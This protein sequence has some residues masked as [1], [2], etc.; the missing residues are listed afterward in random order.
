MNKID[1]LAY[2]KKELYSKHGNKA[3]KL[4]KPVVVGKEDWQAGGGEPTCEKVRA[5]DETEFEW[6]L[7]YWGYGWYGEDDRCNG[8]TK[9]VSTFSEHLDIDL[10]I[11]IL[12]RALGGVVKPNKPKGKKS[13]EKEEKPKMPY[14]D[15][16]KMYDLLFEEKDDNKWELAYKDEFIPKD[17]RFLSCEEM[18]NLWANKKSDKPVTYKE[19]YGIVEFLLG[20]I[21]AAARSSWSG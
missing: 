2:L 3:V 1:Y 9:P 14:K 10:K 4:K 11:K 18:Y 7:E 15:A 5:I 19:M 17:R 13:A 21:S 8:V 16:K 20:E 6:Y 12:E